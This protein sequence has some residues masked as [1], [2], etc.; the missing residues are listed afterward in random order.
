MQKNAKTGAEIIWE[1]LERLGVEYVFGYPGGAIL[2]A[3][4]AMTRYSVHH[5]LVRHEQS[6]THMADGY[7]RASG[8][9]GVA[10]ATSGPGATNMVTGIATAMMDSSPI[11]CITGQVGSSVLGS[12]AFQETDITGITIPIAK[13]NYLVTRA[14]EV[15]ASL[16]EAFQIAASDRPGPVLVDITKD[17]QLGTCEFDWDAAAPRAHRQVPDFFPAP[18]KLNE[19]AA[20]INESQRPVILAGHGII[21]S[22]AGEEV[23]RLAETA[24]IPVALTLLGLGAFPA[25]H[26]LNLGMMGM[27]GEAWV[28]QAIQE[29]DL[30]IALGMRF[31]DRVTGNVR[32]YAPNARKI[33][34][35]IDPAELN[36]I[37]GGDAA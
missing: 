26:P 23:R 16:R 32:T 21:L 22:G 7:A 28:N 17:A 11:V 18:A 6:A 37:I 34:V 5:V 4:D 24:D 19:A 30:L 27:H 9:V 10:L 13:H 29:A 20:L 14:D 36:K 15:A 12:D 2:P 8:R 31:D 1:C 35:D 25:S 33:H 3:Y